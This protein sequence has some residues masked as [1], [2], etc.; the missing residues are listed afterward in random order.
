[1][2][3]SFLAVVPNSDFQPKTTLLTFTNCKSKTNFICHYKSTGI[4]IDQPTG[5]Y[6]QEYIIS[7]S[8][9]YFLASFIPYGGTI[10]IADLFWIIPCIISF[11]FNPNFIN[12]LVYLFFFLGI[13]LT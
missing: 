12:L 6:V 7:I 4:Y 11:H 1:M 3:H 2:I 10:D 9:P 5:S 13:L 8:L